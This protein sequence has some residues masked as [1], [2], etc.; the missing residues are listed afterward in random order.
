MTHRNHITLATFLLALIACPHN[1]ASFPTT[2]SR[3]PI[4]TTIHNNNHHHCRR[5]G[6]IRHHS[7]SS[8]S[9]LYSTLDMPMRPEEREKNSNRTTG[10]TN[11]DDISKI[12]VDDQ[13][14]VEDTTTSS[15]KGWKAV[16]GGFVP[17]FLKK[18]KGPS[19]DTAS[20]SSS[21]T[22]AIY[23]PIQ[24]V[25]TL[26]DYKKEVV[27][28]PSSI[29]VVRFFAPWCKSCKASMPLFKKM[30]LEHSNSNVK[31]VQV[32]LTKD[33]AYI[34]EGLGVPSIPFG[35]I[36]YPNVGL[37][38]EKKINKKVFKDFRDSLDSYVV[39]SCDLPELVEEDVVDDDESMGKEEEE[40]FQ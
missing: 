14:G 27:D 37:V 24:L 13:Q 32:P 15:T 16:A 9:S 19:S 17:K 40:G 29:V 5:V 28:E 36:Y 6:R 11:T 12:N 3:I 31:F 39:G 38:E 34:H 20:K 18:Q 33:T 21:S 35:H 26:Q 22:D 25:D 2:I 30:V 1:S 4:D 10:N 8:S 23:P 7:Y